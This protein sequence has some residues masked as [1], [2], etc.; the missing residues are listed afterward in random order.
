MSE[1]N[2]AKRPQTF[3]GPSSS[4]LVTSKVFHSIE[5]KHARPFSVTATRF[6]PPPSIFSLLCLRRPFLPPPLIFCP[7]HPFFTTPLLN[8]FLCFEPSSLSV[9]TFKDFGSLLRMAKITFFDFFDFFSCLQA[10]RYPTPLN[11]G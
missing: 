5:N 9:R 10:L 2:P 1:S 4:Q 11:L 7:Y 6:Q 3:D 8:F